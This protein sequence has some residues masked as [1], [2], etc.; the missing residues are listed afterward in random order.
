MKNL[1][2]T[3]MSI[4]KRNNMKIKYNTQLKNYEGNR[5]RTNFPPQW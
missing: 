1:L 3:F 5:L 2:P 4:A